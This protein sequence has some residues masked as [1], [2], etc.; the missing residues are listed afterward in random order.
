MAKNNRKHVWKRFTNETFCGL[1]GGESTDF[2]SFARRVQDGELI[3][4]VCHKCCELATPE[5]A[6]ARVS[7]DL[8][9]VP[10]VERV[11]VRSLAQRMVS[12]YVS[13]QGAVPRGDQQRLFDELVVAIHNDLSTGRDPRDLN[14]RRIE[15]LVCGGEEGEDATSTALWPATSEVI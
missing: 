12:C 5:A 7:A 9:V 3:T 1:V 13:E 6:R 2:D 11:L 14:E 8:T 4:D 15:L 10:G